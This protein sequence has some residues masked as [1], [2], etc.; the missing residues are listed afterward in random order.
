MQIKLNSVLVEDQEKALV[1]YTEVL[2]FQ[3]RQDI[4]MGED[5]WLT[6][7]S[8]EGHPDVELLLEPL[9]FEPAVVYQK[10]L[11]GAG[12]PS[13][14]F[15]VDDIGTEYR[16]LIDAGVVFKGEPTETGTSIMATFEDGCGNL[17]L[18]Y[19]VEKP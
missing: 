16:R 9:G 8:P 19:E 12:I 2:G 5:R 11:Y 13:T 4:P 6:V 7:I 15:A 18:I 14:A 10:A 17:I 1:F 3:K